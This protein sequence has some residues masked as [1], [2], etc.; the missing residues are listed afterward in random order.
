MDKAC[1]RR[2]MLRLSTDEFS[3]QCWNHPVIQRGMRVHYSWGSLY[4]VLFS[5]D[6]QCNTQLFSYWTSPLMSVAI[7]SSS[8]DAMKVS[9]QVLL[10][11]WLHCLSLS[12]WV[13]FLMPFHAFS[14]SGY[15]LHYSQLLIFHSVASPWGFPG[16]LAGKEST[17]NAEDPG[18][19]PG[20][21]RSP[22]E[23]IGYPLQY[24]WASLVAQ[25]VKNL[26]AMWET[27]IRSLGW[28]N[29]LKNSMA[30][31]SSILAWRIPRDIGAWWTTVMGSQS[32]TWLSD[33]NQHN[34]SLSISLSAKASSTTHIWWFLN[35]YL[36]P[37]PLSWV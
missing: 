20:S 31:H 21:G 6:S 15:P 23:G 30:T 33:W 5:T 22:G 24:S 1:G 37:G 14:S 26:P 7:P 3:L 36:E 18:L 16:S 12:H 35:L 34:L 4:P 10:I 13:L 27:W 17:Y 29:P 19:I 8:L 11:L 28:E 32:W 2:S 9:L 25:M